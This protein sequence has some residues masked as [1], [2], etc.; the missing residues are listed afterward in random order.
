MVMSEENV[1]NPD[2]APEEGSPDAEETTSE[3][4]ANA[5]AEG[6]EEEPYVNPLEVTTYENAH[7]VDRSK[8]ENVGPTIEEVQTA[9]RDR[10]NEAVAE[11]RAAAEEEEP[12]EEPV[13]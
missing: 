2:E 8:A 13:A 9:E 4:G 7:V 6:T 11:A 5:F 3:T 10:I 12:V 1:V